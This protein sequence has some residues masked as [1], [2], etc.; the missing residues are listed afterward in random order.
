MTFI[1]LN[2][3]NNQL[4]QPSF[5]HSFLLSLGYLNFVALHFF[6]ISKKQNN[7]SNI[8]YYNDKLNHSKLVINNSSTKQLFKVLPKYLQKGSFFSKVAALNY[9]K[10]WNCTKREPPNSYLLIFLA[11]DAS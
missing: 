9:D 4:N 2:V 3:W 6:S 11:I 1:L 10:V 8:N 7:K 5:C